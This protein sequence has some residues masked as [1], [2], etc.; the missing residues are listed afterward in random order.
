MYVFVFH[1]LNKDR[2]DGL[3][4]EAFKGTISK[5]RSTDFPSSTQRQKIDNGWRISAFICHNAEVGC[6]MKAFVFEMAFF[7]P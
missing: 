2:R 1:E 7:S 6:L 5:K 4:L 3:A